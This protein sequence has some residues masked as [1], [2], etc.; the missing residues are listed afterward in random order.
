[1]SKR[2]H[3]SHGYSQHLIR[4]MCEA[5]SSLIGVRFGFKCVRSE[6]PVS[7]IASKFGVSRQTVYNWFCG[8]ASPNE[9]NAK[10]IAALLAG[11]VRLNQLKTAKK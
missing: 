5:D 10:L 11:R 4:K 1:M 8:L 2:A 9:Q 3:I 6:V 7:F